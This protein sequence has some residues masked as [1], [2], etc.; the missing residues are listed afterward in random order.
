[1]ENIIPNNNNMTITLKKEG[2]RSKR[3][4]YID[5]AFERIGET[6]I[7][8]MGSKMWIIK[9]DNSQNVLVKFEDG[10]ICN[11]QYDSFKKGITKN[12]FDK[13]VYGI[14]Y[15]GAGKY[16]SKID[17]K[18]T[19]QYDRWK[20]ML[21]RCYSD[22]YQ[23]KQPTYIGCSVSDEWLNFQNFAEWY[24]KNYYEIDGHIM[25]LDKD[26][27]CKGNK[28]YSSKT[29]VFAPSNINTLFVKNDI[30]RGIY[31]IGVCFDK[32][33]NKFKATYR[34][35]NIK[36]H[37]GVFETSLEAFNAYKLYK[38]KFI[39]ITAEQ[40]K[41]CIPIQLYTAMIKYQVEITD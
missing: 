5:L 35:K 33:I 4:E 29:C 20:H 16:K 3:Q 21:S 2:N 8:K 15:M 6:V 38:E 10:F 12:P 26:I 32:L 18:M 14:G 23:V 30:I 28:I 17:S 39:K 19:V 13:S 25:D 31:P 36:K 1:M 22:K 34:N 24:D 7:N 27:L 41:K 9:Y 11:T 37:L 40:Y